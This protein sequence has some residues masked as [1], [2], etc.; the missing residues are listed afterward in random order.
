MSAG[1]T[2]VEPIDYVNRWRHL[3]AAREEQGRRLDRLS[4]RPDHWA[5]D[6]A[7]RFRQMTMRPGASDPLMDLIRPLVG[8]NSSVLDV[9]AGA[10]RHV[11][12]LAPLVS[13]VVAVEPSPAMRAQL[14]VVVAE[15]GLKNVEIIESSWPTDQV[16]PADLVICSHVAYFVTEIEPFL[17]R[18][19]HV[20]R[21]R[22]F[23]V[24][25]HVQREVAILD[26]FER[27]WHEPRSPEPSFVDL[28]GVAAQLGLFPNVK[29][30]SFPIVAGFKSI[31]DALP[32]VRADLLNPEGP[33]IDQTIRE[34]LD[35][36]MVYRDGR[37]QFNVPPTYAGVLWWE[38]SS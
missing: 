15:A 14:E 32:M 23:V 20:N 22:A 28:F 3:V 2:T 37:W 4:D 30:I 31:E 33:G 7:A 34:Y 21:G 12:P 38:A 16:D 5:G 19:D 13:R 17:R 26:L 27:I 11:L 18:I 25:R 8:P 6:R 1:V 29:T 10:G 9:G 35:E 24:L 36:R